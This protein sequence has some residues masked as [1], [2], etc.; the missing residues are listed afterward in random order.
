ML[1]FFFF[2]PPT[3]GGGGLGSGRVMLSLF[4]VPVHPLDV[5]ASIEAASL[6]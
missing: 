3:L 4:E 5:I 6:T 2:L 1:F